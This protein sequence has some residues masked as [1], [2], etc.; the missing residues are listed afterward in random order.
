[1]EEDADILTT[2][3]ANSMTRDERTSHWRSLVD[4]QAQSGLSAA[5]FCRDHHLKVAQFYRWRRRFRFEQDND[6][7]NDFLQLIPSS[8]QS[9]SGI[10]IHLGNGL[11]IELD[12]VFDPHTLRTA[13][14]ALSGR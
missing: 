14:E 6:M 12:R 2:A 5:A 9:S 4:E 11:S 1:L 10:R 13:I 8:K 3:G 7:P